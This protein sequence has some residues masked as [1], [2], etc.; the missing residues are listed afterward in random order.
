MKTLPDYDLIE[1]SEMIVASWS[2]D[3]KKTGPIETLLQIPISEIRHIGGCRSIDSI[4]GSVS[5]LGGAKKF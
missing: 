3:G 5:E 1:P 4:Y 2:K